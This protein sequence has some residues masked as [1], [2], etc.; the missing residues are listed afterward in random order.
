MLVKGLYKDLSFINHLPPQIP[1]SKFFPPSLYFVYL[2]P[3]DPL[4]V[5]I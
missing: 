2:F 5:K 1:K 4:K 3:K